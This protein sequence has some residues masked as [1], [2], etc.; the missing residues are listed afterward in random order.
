MVVNDFDI[1]RAVS[2]PAEADTPLIVD[3]NGV[4]A[5][6]V[7]FESF[8]SI[9]GRNA[10]V[11]QFRD[12]VKLGELAQGSALNVRRECADFL[13]PKQAGS[14]VAGK[15]TDHALKLAYSNGMR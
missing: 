5:F 12:G 9:A 1:M 11:N 13:Q 10:Q 2:F 6:A 4:L 3:T 7:A 15:G 14:G 8:Q